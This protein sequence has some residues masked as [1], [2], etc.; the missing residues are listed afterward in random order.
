MALKG[1]GY[2]MNTDNE[3]EIEEAYV[4]LIQCVET[5]DPEI[6]TDEIIDNI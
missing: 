5:I 4:W 3:Q 6:V 1:L 2:S